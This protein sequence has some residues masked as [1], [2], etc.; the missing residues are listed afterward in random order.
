MPA[1]PN[2]QWFRCVLRLSATALPSGKAAHPLSVGEA[3]VKGVTEFAGLQ[4]D[5]IPLFY[6]RSRTGSG[7][8]IG[9]HR[10]LDLQVDLFGGGARDA[11]RWLDC[12]AHYF[13]EGRPGRNFTVQVA[14]GLRTVSAESFLL[15][16]G[17][18]P[19]REYCLDFRTPLPFQTT[20]G[21]PRFW[22]DSQGLRKVL[23]AR[24][25]KLFGTAAVLP[26]AELSV[27]PYYWEYRQILHDSSS[28][29]GHVKYLNGCAGPLYL[30][31]EPDALSAWLPWL[32]LAEAV[33]LGGKTSF[34]LGR[35]VL[36]AESPAY[37]ERDLTDP[38]L[39]ERM[40]RDVLEEEDEALP[41]WTAAPDD[42]RQ[43]EAGACA[44]ALRQ[45]WQPLPYRA[46]AVPKAEAGG[47]RIVEKAPFRER[48]LQR[49][50]FNL[51]REVLDRTFE[52]ESIG[53]RK[54]LSRQTAVDRLNAALAEGYDYV[55]ESDIA[56]F[57]PSVRIGKLLERLD[58]LLPER[59][60]LLRRTLAAVLNAPRELHGRIE[61]RERGLAVGSP[62]S[63]MLANVYLDA[64]D[65]K[66]KS[67]GVHLI[68]FA[69]DFIILTRG[70]EAAEELLGFAGN[71]LKDW[72]LQLNLD[73]TAIRP[74][75]QG[76]TF[77]GIRFSGA[78]GELAQD[79]AHVR[80][81]KPVYVTEPF[82]FLGVD[83]DC[84]EVRRH[85]EL[86]ASIPLR[87]IG[88]IVALRPCCW[89]SQLAVRCAEA[90]IPI[91][92][93]AGNG[94]PA[95]TL[96]GG[97]AKHYQTAYRQAAKFYAL[98]EAQRLSIAK[99]F[100]T[101]KLH[102]YGALIRQR[103]RPGTN[104]LL[105]DLKRLTEKMWDAP[106]LAVLRGLESRAAS[107]TFQQFG[108]WIESADFA[109]QGRKR[110]P[111]D[112]I[113][114]L[115]NFAYHLLFARISV[116]LRGEGL[117]PFLGFLH[118]PTDRYEALVC[119]IQELFRPHVDRLVVKLINLSMLTPSD[120]TENEKGFWLSRQG[121]TCVVDQFS[122]EFD[123]SPKQGSATLNEALALQVRSVRDFFLHDAEIQVFSW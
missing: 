6:W 61:P 27:L 81:R 73:K 31:A 100:A 101:G 52:E 91:V 15:P 87:R 29:T 66:I 58:G 49:H 69:D 117:N 120:F 94:R 22:L 76:F 65:E 88:E 118:E 10:P 90:E 38:V 7:M 59:D 45:G 43:A 37:F 20:P 114:S 46:F 115:L 26:E 79:G 93:T 12:A 112:R 75:D 78:P 5:L 36:L 50:L 54:G 85:G 92:L 72:G 35:F 107:K 40:F 55:L 13:D 51:L 18:N 11:E 105:H 28:Q 83:A 97:A 113:N 74:I 39:L 25:K 82:V 2:F 111:P 47:V 63:P 3:I 68:R 53:F 98:G 95:A 110:R 96:G 16:A 23:L 116:L 121:K 80:E 34:G 89:S 44:E 30:K 102:N 108:G 42:G 77:L 57:F 71:Y 9:F 106:D 103:Y 109:W 70:R 1:L 84:L 122:R 33:G 48:V 123:R 8:R 41:A 21:K 19:A 86:L 60:V 67:L 17:G 62:L 99:L 32:Q 64:F 104:D 24:V 119:D 56:D 14:E 4:D